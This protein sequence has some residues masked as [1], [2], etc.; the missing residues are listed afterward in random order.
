MAYIS[1]ITLPSGTTYDIK[2][3]KAW[4]D[5]ADIREQLASGVSFHVCTSADDTPE[6]VTWINGQGTTITGTLQAADVPDKSWIYLV[7]KRGEI[8]LPND[9]QTFTNA[10][11]SPSSI[12]LRKYW[13]NTDSLPSSGTMDIYELNS[14]RVEWSSSVDEW[15]AWGDLK[16]D[17]V[18]CNATSVTS[19]SSLHIDDGTLSSLY[20]INDA[21]ITVTRT[22]I[23]SE[24]I[25]IDQGTSS[26]HDYEWEKIG[27]TSIDLSNLG[28]L[29]F[30]DSA[31]GQILLPTSASF[32]GSQTT[33]GQASASV[34]KYFHKGVFPTL[35]GNT[36]FVTGLTGGATA[37]I[38]TTG[39]EITVTN[40]VLNL[41]TVLYGTFNGGTLQGTSTGE[42]GLSS[43]TL[44][45]FND[46]SSSAD[47]SI[48]AAS[49]THTHTNTATGSVS[50]ST[51]LT[52][53]TVS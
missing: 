50:L 18:L 45:S 12:T 10:S 1:K 38:T 22:D 31:S 27:D 30:K 13:T 7:P 35:T 26:S 40:E 53:I 46:T 4:T 3:A 48:T 42:V 41:S 14:S 5:I 43:G 36:T 6:G 47:G 19:A 25:V 28:L 21:T 8:T 44:P 29:A 33:T 52:T 51:T 34:T 20:Q 37:S 49:S 15:K 24:Y 23:Y 9:Q 32:S 11:A 39:Q 17:D 16:Y 2:D